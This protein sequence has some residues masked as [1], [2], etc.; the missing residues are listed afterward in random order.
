MQIQESWKTIFKSPKTEQ[1]MKREKLYTSTANCV[2]Q[3]I[4]KVV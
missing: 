2:I 1:K 3:S 4:G